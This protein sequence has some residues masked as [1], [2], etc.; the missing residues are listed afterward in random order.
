MDL[1]F[2][3]RGGD[4][5]ADVPEIPY[6]IVVIYENGKVRAAFGQQLQ[7]TKVLRAEAP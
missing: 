6:L 7:H 4:P 2:K 3:E 5:T 1:S